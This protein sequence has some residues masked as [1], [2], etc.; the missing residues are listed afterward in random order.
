VGQDAWNVLPWLR[1]MRKDPGF[2][3]PGASGHYRM[4]AAGRLQREPAWA[5]FVDGRPRKLPPPQAMAQAMQ[6]LGPHLGPQ[7]GS[8][9]GPQ[10]AGSAPVPQRNPASGE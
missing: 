1:L 3:F 6:H 2:V 7:P 8:Q 4:D 9:P 5:V 10:A